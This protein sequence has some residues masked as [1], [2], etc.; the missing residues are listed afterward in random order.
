MRILLFGKNGQLGWELNRTLPTLG[1]LVVVD[2][3]DVDFNQPQTLPE[4]VRTARPDVIINAVAYT[5]V[6]K[7][8]SEPEIARR[9]NADSVGEIARTARELGSLLVHISTDY[10]FDG[11]KG[12]PYVETDLP[13]PLGVYAGSKLAAEQAI[14]QAGCAHLTL[15]SAWLYSRRG[16]N[17]LLKVLKWARSY[18]VLRLANDQIGNPTA[19]PLLAKAITQVLQRPISQLAEKSAIYH[20]AGEGFTSRYELGLEIL[21]RDPHPEDQVVQSIVRAKITDF[22]AQAIRPLNTALDCGKIKTSLGIQLPPWQDG[23]RQI[24]Q[25]GKF[26]L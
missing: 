10:V 18:P 20:L 21:G 22:P 9:V 12:S 15:R 4:I 14:Q 7:A 13:N 25:H 16:D 19:A 17:F 3:P 24:L 1:E 8:E 26:D 11:T 2:Y 6:D 5:N 23:V